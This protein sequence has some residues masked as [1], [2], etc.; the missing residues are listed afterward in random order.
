VRLA[1][2]EGQTLTVGFMP[3]LI[4]T[5]LVHHLERRFLGLG[6]EVVR[7]S[8]TEQI[9][10]L[11]NGRFD[12]CLAH[13]P[14]DDEGLTVVDLY[15]EPRA[16]ALPIGHPHAGRD[17]LTVVLR[18]GA[19]R[20]LGS[21]VSAAVITAARS[22][23]VELAPIRVNVV[24]PGVVRTPLWSAVPS[25]TLDR[26]GADTLLG[27]VAGPAEQAEAYLGLMSQTYVTGSVA[28][29]DGGSALR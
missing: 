15:S 16:V 29:V 1:G 19:G 20:L 17:E 2:R 9:L 21:T 22:L 28:V 23:A 13:R 8:W 24:A 25:S 27:R 26:L 5:P 11:R 7:T 4:L 3:G 10:G 6:V 14:F 12:A 18:G